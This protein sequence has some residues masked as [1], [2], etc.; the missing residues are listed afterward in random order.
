MQLGGDDS[1]RI[2]PR[3]GGQHLSLALGERAIALGQCI[4]SRAGSTTR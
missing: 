2:V 1:D 3:R 4:G